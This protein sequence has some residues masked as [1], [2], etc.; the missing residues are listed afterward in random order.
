MRDSNYSDS[1]DSLCVNSIRFLAVDAVQNA[2]SGHP[3]LPMGAASMAYV[4]WTRFLKHN[5]ADPGW[6]D[7]DRFVLSAGHG[8]MLLYAL[9]YL[10]GY[11]LPLEQIKQFRQ[12][13][14]MTPGHPERGITP[15]VEVTAGPLGQ[16]V[17]NAVGMAIAE[18]H[19]GAR[20]NRP[21]HEIIDHFTYALVSDGDLMEGVGSES[22]SLAGQLRLAKLICLYDNNNITLS[23]STKLAFTEDRAK[24]FEAYGW[25]TR[26]VD[27]G[28]DLDAIDQAIREAQA[29]VD[30][31]SLILVRTHIGYGSPH[32]QDT[33]EAHGSPLGEDEVKLTKQNLGWPLDP[34][35]YVPK[36]VLDHF[37]KALEVGKRAEVE[38]KERFSK[39]ERAFPDAAAML[40]RMTQAGLPK[41]WD[42]GIPSFPADEKGMATRV[43]SGK[44]LNAAAAK[45]P[46]IIGGSADLNPST[47]T[48]LLGMGDFQRP[49]AVPENVQ[50]AV[51]GGWSYQGRNLA[52]GVREHG[53]GAITNGLAAHG[54]LLPYCATFLIFTDYMRPPMRLAALSDLH[55]IYVLTHD[56]IGL[57]EDGPTHQ[58]VEQLANLRA[59]PRMIVIRPC[60]ANE[61]AVAWRVA[62]ETQDMPVALILTRQSVPTLDRERYASA[63][64]LYRGAY[65][66]LDPPDGKP[67]L[68]LIATGSEISLIISAQEQLMKDG[69]RVRTVSMP[70]W[71]LFESQ[72]QEYR[73]SVLPASVHARLSVEAGST[74]GWRR[75]VGDSGDVIGLDHFG[76]S[77]PGKTVM[78]EFGFTV[79]NVVARAMDLLEGK[80]KVY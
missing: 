76:A 19:L 44:I 62:V 58:P 66:L 37:R 15:G 23:A 7:R 52:Y 29:E 67:D 68:I 45:V 16:G 69:I 43:A 13:H 24:R 79:E 4:L 3:G 77:A 34:P 53:M 80:E 75:Y 21:D 56:S 40:Q 9:L 28:N 5:P 59:I 27:D 1:L 55:V 72:T 35:F 47:H 71:E 41:D 74:Q 30:R 63:D 36:D 54:G 39:Y 14:S 57:G 25:H 64:G 2:N 20:F 70:S 78:S 60:D 50:G 46:R 61:T 12:W 18:A 6:L 8:S 32:K 73:D 26:S 42:K 22:A 51:G 31:P 49:S 65:V 11:D 10:T 33:Y 38:W 48:A 17:G